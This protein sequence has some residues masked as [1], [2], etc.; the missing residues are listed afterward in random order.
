MCLICVDF[1]KGTLTI[2]EAFGNLQEMRETLPDE[3]YDEVVGM[4]ID[5]IYEA[6]EGD[7]ADV[8]VADEQALVQIFDELDD[9]D[10]LDLEWGLD[11]AFTNLFE[12]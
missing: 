6:Y 2:A 5:K 8:S 4:L 9:G 1:Q 12:D 11:G 3:H 7:A 10:Q